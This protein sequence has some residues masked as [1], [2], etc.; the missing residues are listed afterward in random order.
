[1][2]GIRGHIVAIPGVVDVERLETESQ[3]PL[4][5]PQG[6]PRIGYAGFLEELKGIGDLVTAF[7]QVAAEHPSAALLVA[8]DGPERERL[9][10]LA[11]RPRR[12]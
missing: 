8:G 11:D 4:P 10:A 1:M 6:A 7:A 3:L 12:G 5:L 2:V 9:I